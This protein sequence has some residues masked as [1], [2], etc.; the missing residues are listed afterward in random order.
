MGTPSPWPATREDQLISAPTVA[1][2]RTTITL[3]A[4]LISG[5]GV[6]VLIG[7]TASPL[8]I[9]LVVAL[10]AALAMV[11]VPPIATLAFLFLVYINAP[12]VL[13][14]FHGLPY[15]VG[16]AFIGLLAIPTISMIMRREPFTFPPIMVLVTIYICVLVASSLVASHFDPAWAAMLVHV[17]EGFVPVL[18]L[19]NFVRTPAMLRAAI[20]AL[21]LAG[22]FMGGLS[23]HQELTGSYE[24]PYGGFAQIVGR[25]FSPEGGE[26]GE[27]ILRPRLAGPIHEQNRYAQVMIVL[28]PLAMAIMLVEKRR[29]LRLVAAAAGVLS[30]AAVVLSF[31]RGAA[32]VLFGL[33][34]A[35]LALR[36]IRLRMAAPLIALGLIAVLSVAP[37]FTS[38][39]ASLPQA[40]EAL[41]E[42]RETTDLSILGRITLN[43]AAYQMF[44][45]HPVLGVGLANFDLLSVDYAN[46]LGLRHISLPYRA[47]NLYLEVAAET[48]VVGLASFLGLLGY[49]LWQLW[50]CRREAMKLDHHEHARIATALLYGLFAYLGTALFLHMAYER[51]FWILIAVC[52]A[53]AYVIRT[54]LANIATL[55]RG[56]GSLRDGESK[57]RLLNQG[58]PKVPS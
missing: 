38:R 33:L 23:V 4:A 24:D 35:A 39:I 22:L 32:I 16:G 29:A 52:A 53:A 36:H 20:W 26:L 43:L 6:A 55:H 27:R 10:G 51:Y 21:L 8:G 14:N 12:V 56:E 9:L 25:G 57:D 48:G 19:V 45:E 40:T 7:L 41:T 5:L 28:V 13:V 15:I 42:G 18:L 30:L 34:V 44:V 31:S 37:D 46:P 58:A 17:Q 3:A 49:V 47:H 1:A 11:M 50:R 54:D 2:R